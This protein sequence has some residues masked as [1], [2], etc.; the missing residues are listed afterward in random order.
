MAGTI[1]MKTIVII[2]VLFFTAQGALASQ[3]GALPFSEFK[4]QSEGIGESGVI[5]VKD[6]SVGSSLE[7]SGFSLLPKPR[8]DGMFTFQ[9]PA[10]W[11]K[12]IIGNCMLPRRFP[13][14]GTYPK[15]GCVWTTA[16]SGA[17]DV[18]GM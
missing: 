6:E 5:T 13:I 10:L 18:D 7:I 1:K 11:P 12:K 3:E 17:A 4:I 15:I 2:A 8:R 16:R 9:R 14:S